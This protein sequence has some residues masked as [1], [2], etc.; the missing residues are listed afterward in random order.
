LNQIVDFGESVFDD[1]ITTAIVILFTNRKHTYTEKTE[2]KL[3]EIMISEISQKEFIKQDYVISV[4]IDN[5]NKI[6]LTKLSEGSELLGNITKEL[7]FGVVIT[8]NQDE[9]VSNKKINN[10]KP[11]LEG[12]DIGSYYIK[13]IEKYLNYEPSL[14]HR[15]RTKKI[16]EAPEKV[17][18][19]RI[20][21]GRN[22]LKAAYDNKQYYNKESINNLILKEDCEYDIKYI[23]ALLN[24]KLINWY[25]VNRFTNK[26]SLTVNLSKKYLSKIPIKKVSI[27]T[28]KDFVKV[29]DEILVIKSENH[30]ADANILEKEIDQMVYKLY[31]LTEEEIRIV[32]GKN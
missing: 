6:I 25:Y 9:I 23:L 18:I 31:G 10:W 17:L 26:S 7:I 3:N 27:Q 30:L 28:Q 22:P 32:E 11:F 12:K 29:V 19:Q 13:P 5:D 24:S 2:I 15:P 14:L 16:F 1:A 20:T 21:G 4:S 8:K